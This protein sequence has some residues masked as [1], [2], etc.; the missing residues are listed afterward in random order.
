MLL[1]VSSVAPGRIAAAEVKSYAASRNDL[2]VE[3]APSWWYDK[4]NCGPAQARSYVMQQGCGFQSFQRKLGTLAKANVAC[5]MVWDGLA[6]VDGSVNGGLLIK[7]SMHQINLC[8]NSI[9]GNGCHPWNQATGN[10]G[11]LG[12]YKPRGQILEVDNPGTSGDHPGLE[13][14]DQRRETLI[15]QRRGKVLQ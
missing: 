6:G 14:A 11:I 8:I 1:E 9:S 5:C 12:V 10:K 15:H 7:V 2:R 4:L 13:S 3:E